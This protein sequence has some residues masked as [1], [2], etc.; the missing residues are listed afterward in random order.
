MLIIGISLFFALFVGFSGSGFYPA[1][2]GSAGV[3]NLQ[4]RSI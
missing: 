3:F 1:I 4:A 2:L